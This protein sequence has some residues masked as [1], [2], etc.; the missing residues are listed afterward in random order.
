MIGGSCLCGGVTWEADGPFELMSHCHCSMCRKAHG[1]AY[2]TYVAAPADGFRQR[3]GAD[4][5]RHYESSPGNDRRFCGR[6]GSV[7]PSAAEA[8]RV[9]MP[10]GNL[11]GDPDVRPQAHIF[12]GSKAPWH[13]ITDELPASDAYPP[14]WPAAEVGPRQRPAATDESVVRGSCLCGDVAYEVSGTPTGIVKCHCSRCRKGRSAAH[15]ANL[16]VANPQ[17]RW[18]QGADRVESYRVPGARFTNNFCRRCG[19]L[20]PRPDPAPDLLGIP[21]GGI[22]RCPADV[23]EKVNIFVDSKAP[24]FEIDDGLP[25]REE[26]LLPKTR[27]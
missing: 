9:F 22:D 2:A 27:G 3:T 14:D 25:Q 5:V 26:G 6:C 20:L 21:A 23:G 13:P 16:F 10:A 4:L 17:L 12:V 7:L 19:S 11:D 8:G 1:S 24:W 18:L 15:G